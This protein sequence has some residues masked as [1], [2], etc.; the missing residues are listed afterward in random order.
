MDFAREIIEDFERADLVVAH[1]LS[2]DIMF[3]TKELERLNKIMFL[4]D[5]FC[6]MK[7]TT[8]LCKIKKANCLGYKYP[9]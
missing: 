9:N 4:K 1:N 8:A 2:F 5:G 3:L 6:S 7:G